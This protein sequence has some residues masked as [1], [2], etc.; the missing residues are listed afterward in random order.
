[1]TAVEDSLEKL[2]KYIFSISKGFECK[3]FFWLAKGFEQWLDTILNGPDEP[4][5]IHTV[6]N[7]YLSNIFSSRS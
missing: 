6:L 4:G 1:M 2:K 3:Q 7:L 5:I